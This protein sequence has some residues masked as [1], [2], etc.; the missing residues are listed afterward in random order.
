MITKNVHTV[1]TV[2]V[3]NI[4]AGVAPEHSVPTIIFK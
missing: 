4:L 3:A 1:S 2:V